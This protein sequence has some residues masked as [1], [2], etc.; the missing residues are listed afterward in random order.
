[1]GMELVAVSVPVYVS[2]RIAEPVDLHRL[3]QPVTGRARRHRM[4]GTL[5]FL[6][7]I[8]APFVHVPARLP[9]AKITVLGARIAFFAIKDDA[10]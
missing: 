7:G 3:A 5:D 2:P 8:T 1:M 9:P 4:S 6:K 10:L